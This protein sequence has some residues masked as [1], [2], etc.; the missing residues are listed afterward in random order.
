VT[1]AADGALFARE[2]LLKS[3]GGWAV[4]AKAE[5]SAVGLE[6]RQHAGYAPTVMVVDSS[7]IPV[8]LILQTDPCGYALVTGALGYRQGF[9]SF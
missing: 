3:V 4:W 8:S 7:P 5:K 2:R 6:P 9:V 1:E